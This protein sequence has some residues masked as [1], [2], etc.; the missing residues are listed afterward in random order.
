MT[1]EYEFFKDFAGV[2]KA[3]LEMFKCG[4]KKKKIT[5]AQNGNKTNNPHD[6]TEAKRVGSNIKDEK[7]EDGTITRH[8]VRKYDD[9]SEERMVEHRSGTYPNKVI[10]H[11]TVTSRTG[12]KYTDNPMG[13]STGAVYNPHKTDSVRNR[14]YKASVPN[15]ARAK[16]A[17][18]E[19]HKNKQKKK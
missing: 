13:N 11:T 18:A 2:T 15:I 10:G 5:K 1:Q 12:A 7:H 3:D 19:Y 14:T 16:Q 4:G 8:T 9:G 6:R 17:D